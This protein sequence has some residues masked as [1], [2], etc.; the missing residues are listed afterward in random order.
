MENSAIEA[1]RQYREKNQAALERHCS[2][3]VVFYS[4]DGI[5]IDDSVIIAADA[6]IMPGT[7]LRGST[8]IGARS[9]IGPNSL[10]EN[11][12]VGE[13]VKFNASQGYNS[14]IDDGAA[15]GPF[16]HIRPDSHICERV[17]VGDFVE[18]K[19]STIGAGTSVSHLTYVG[20]SDV[21]KSCNFGCGCVTVNYDGAEKHRNTIGD[22]AFIGCN[23][24][25][26][27]PVSIGD[28]AYTAAGSTITEDV[29]PHSLGIARAR[30]VTKEGWA[31]NK[32]ESYVEKQ[33]KR[34]SG[35]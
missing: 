32:L 27:A 25:L 26:V 20:D 7:I 31:Q 6:V 14:V 17:H 22:Y 19:N 11:V 23:T 8:V 24:N 3:G 12:R 9:I 33:K 4:F 28:G 35:T 29:P 5:L 21:G 10:L 2:A 13:D 16:V 18:I 1:F 15:I 34:E 30:Q